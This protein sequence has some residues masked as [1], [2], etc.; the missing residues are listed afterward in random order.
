MKDVQV[1]YFI[2]SVGGEY[3]E[4]KNQSSNSKSRGY[5][6]SQKN[7]QNKKEHAW[8]DDECLDGQNFA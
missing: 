2:R 5:P 3:I 4:I 6:K 1:E 7:R 8:I